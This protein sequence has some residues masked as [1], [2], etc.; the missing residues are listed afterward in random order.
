M[1]RKSNHGGPRKAGLGKTMGRPLIHAEQGEMQYKN[2][3]LPVAW[4]ERITQAGK[5]VYSEGVRVLVAQA[6][7]IQLD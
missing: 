7:E 4:T 6:L 5:G 1:K 3:R 2:I